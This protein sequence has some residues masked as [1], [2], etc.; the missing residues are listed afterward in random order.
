MGV[1]FIGERGKF[2]D[3][4]CTSCTLVRH[5]LTTAQYVTTPSEGWFVNPSG[6]RIAKHRGLSFYTIGQRPGLGGMQGKWFI[7][8]KGLGENGADILVVPGA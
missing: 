7:A 8:K 6:E 4:V 5:D 1:C 3:F 2:G